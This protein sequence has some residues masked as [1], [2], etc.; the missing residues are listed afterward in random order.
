MN[1]DFLWLIIELMNVGQ[2]VFSLENCECGI[3]TIIR[4]R[5]QEML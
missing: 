2:W 4:T 5:G 1:Y 3:Y